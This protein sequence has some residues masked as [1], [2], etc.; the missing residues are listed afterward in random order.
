M[1]KDNRGITMVEILVAFTVLAIVML[2]FYNCL[3]FCGNMMNRAVDVD[4]ENNV[5]QSA[6]AEHFKTGYGL[7]ASNSADYVFKVKGS[8]G[9][10]VYTESFKYADVIFEYKDGNYVIAEGTTGDLRKLTVFSTD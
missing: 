7:G 10:T 8:D 2:V 5:F 6:S 9:S 1:K 3:K 4:R